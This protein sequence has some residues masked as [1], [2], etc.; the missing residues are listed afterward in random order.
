[1][2]I[3]K[4]QWRSPKV[5]LAFATAL[6]IG[7]SLAWAQD[8]KVTGTNVPPK[9]SPWET[10]AAVGFTL[11]EGNS[12]TLLATLTLGTTRKWEQ[13]E[14]G[15]GIGGGYGEDQNAN[16][17]VNAEFLTAFGQ[18]NRLITER[19]YAG[20][21]ADFNYDGIANL[22]YRVTITPLAGY[23]LIK[24]TN[25]TLAFE[26]GPSAVFQKYE[27]QS[28]DTYLG[29]RFSERFEQK[30]SATTKFWESVSYTPQVDKWVDNY[31][32]TGEAGI[33]AAINT[34]WSLRVVFQDI[35]TSL[36]ANGKKPND[37]RLIA[38]TAYKF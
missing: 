37:M 17:K 36:P 35:Y 16:P 11:T 2:R 3:I 38:G 26:V 24:N 15:F 13:N 6:L 14:L 9:K 18:Y 28:Q 21:R 31:I 33:D 12:Q 34:H 30:L 22:E 10:T 27:G 29:I 23:Y 19:F 4:P 25:T 5:G 8:Q 32:I 1:M 7:T 20:L